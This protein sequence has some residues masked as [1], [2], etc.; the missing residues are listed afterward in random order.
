MKKKYSIVIYFYRKMHWLY[1]KGAR[2]CA[3]LIY[4]MI[5]ILFGCSIPPSVVLETGVD[6]PHYHGIVIHQDTVVGSGTL[7]YQNVTIGGRNGETGVTIGENCVVGAGAVILGH[8]RIGN[9]VSIGANAV[10]LHDIPDNATAV[11][12]PAKIIHRNGGV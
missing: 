8:V 6:I 7:I 11:G 5:Q 9:N 1:C 10:V 4:H 3:S 2:R 12:V